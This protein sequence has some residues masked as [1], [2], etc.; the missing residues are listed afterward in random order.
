MNKIL[1]CFFVLVFMYS[2]TLVFSETGPRV[3]EY[4]GNFS[5]RPPINWSVREFPGLKYK[6]VIGPTEG[7][8]AVNINF[9]DEIF[10]GNLREYINYNISQFPV[11][12]VGYKL[13]SRSEFKT[14]SGIIGERLTVNNIQDGNLLKQVF[15]FFPALRNRYFVITC[16]TLD[17]VSAKY[18]SIFDES[19]KTFELIK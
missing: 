4:N 15:Y 5:Y 10:N 2:S 6:V 19:M 14:N 7:K 18:L 12:F 1:R 3:Q 8:F 16:S 11:Y 13:L 17:S 9:V